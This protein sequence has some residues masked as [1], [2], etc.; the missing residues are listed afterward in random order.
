MRSRQVEDR[1]CE[2]P[3]EPNPNVDSRLREHRDVWSK[4]ATL[5]LIYEDYHRLLL[6]SCPEGAILEI[7]SGSGHLKQLNSAV[8]SVDVLK[9]PWVDVVADA[10]R[11]PFPAKSF[12]GVVLLDVLHHLER[13]A[14]FFDEVARVLVPG[15]RL[16]MIEPGVTPVSWPFFKFFHQ[17]PID[18]SADP[19][20]WKQ[21]LETHD[22]FD[23]NQAIPTLLFGRASGRRRFT[24]RFRTLQIEQVKWFGLFAYPLSG[25]FKS[26]CLLPPSLVPPLLAFERILVPWIGRLLAFRLFVVVSKPGIEP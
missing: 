15:G 3:P 19:Y 16:V 9:S 10:H 14:A 1:R 12:S 2:L 22:P 23:S 6:R 17:E 11:L 18:L 24:E 13:P 20:A 5:R 21:P 7:G 8:I 4:K 26:W 25:G